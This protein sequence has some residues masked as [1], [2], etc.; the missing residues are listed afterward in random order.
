MNHINFGSFTKKAGEVIRLSGALAG[1]LG[2]TY[3]G[4]EHLLMAILEDGGNSASVILNKNGVTEELV[5]AKIIVLVGKGTPCRLTVD[6]MTP[7]ACKILN[8]AVTLSEGFGGDL[9]GTEHILTL[10]LRQTNSCAL[11]ILKELDVNLSR[12]YN[13][14]SVAHHNTVA[15]PEQN[16]GKLVKLEKY[17][18]EFT[19]STVAAAFDPVIAREDE[20]R[21]IIEILCRRAKNNPCLVGEAGVGKTAIV[22]GLAQRICD[23]SV[24]KELTTK[25]IYS[26]DLTMLLA[27]AKYRGDFEERLKSCIDEAIAAGNVV[28]FIDEIHSI[29]GAGAAEGAIDAAS[30]IKPQLARGG[31]QIIGATTFDE[32]RKNIEK[33]AA[34]ARRFQPVKIDEPDD[35]TTLK[36]ISGLA[37]RYED[38]H[39]VEISSAAL[40]EAVRLS[41]R[42]LNERFFPDKAIDL[43]DEACA[44]VRLSACEEKKS[45]KQL[46]SVFNDYIA[47]K[48]T[49]Q[50]YLDALTKK[51]PASPIRPCVQPAD[52]AAVVAGK[53]GIPAESLSKDE[54]ARLLKLQED[55]NR[56][57][58]GQE[59]AVKVLAEAV[60]RG[61]SGIKSPDRPVGSFIFLGPS[62][63]GKTQLSKALAQSVF[64]RE[65]AIIRIDMSEYMEKHNVSRLIGS[66]PGYVGFEEGGQLTE[67]VRRKPYSIILL[68]EIEK[69]HPDVFNILLQILDEGYVTDSAGRRFSFKNCILI[70]T[71]NLGIRQIS[72]NRQL[73]FTQSAGSDSADRKI[74]Q[75]ELK[76]FFSPELLNRIDEVVIFN[77][78][79]P[80]HLLGIVRLQLD[81]LVLRAKQLGI[82]MDYTDALV[83]KIAAEG[84]SRVNGAREIR[85]IVTRRIEN[86]L[87][88]EILRHKSDAI[89]LDVRDN[90]YAAISAVA[91]SSR[92]ALP[93]LKRV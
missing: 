74:I 75:D 10:I 50:Q 19:R 18:R 16:T 17:A 35:E 86:L 71:S 48:I 36:I 55:M 26:L 6:D 58:I 20:I 66:P 76:K 62:G 1:K 9:A 79:T 61:R 49:N 51:A 69:A 8:G 34:L 22:E 72:D 30:I 82:S 73:G 47:G 80:D 31:L 53:T 39:G 29:M 44:R 88:D 60:R 57:V 27:G 21:R 46:A 54:S 93:D 90:D 14:C 24:P 12:L 77:H 45:C 15:Y 63:V 52:I 38:H 43:I 41:G 3:I 25:R 33:D 37:A 89:T 59:S 91:A 65:D 87:S 28:L 13:D 78:L 81:A 42:Y 2:H 4:S 7:T 83:E 85:R 92:A 64:A 11:T 56:R 84:Y 23:G 5:R 40:A 70:M 68:D 67:Q 32:Y